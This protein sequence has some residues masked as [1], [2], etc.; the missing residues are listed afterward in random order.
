MFSPQR[1]QKEHFFQK[2]ISV[3]LWFIG[4]NHASLRLFF[5]VGLRM[6]SGWGRGRNTILACRARRE[7]GGQQLDEMRTEELTRKANGH[8]T[9]GEAEDGTTDRFE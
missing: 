1:P 5:S 6:S 7:H 4:F 3:L 2:H 8:N 9:W